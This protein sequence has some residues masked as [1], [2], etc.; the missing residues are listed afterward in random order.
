MQNST[1]GRPGNSMGQAHEFTIIG[2]LK[3][4]GAV[5]MR[6]VFEGGFIGKRREGVDKVHTVHDLRFVT[7][8]NDTRM[9]FAST[10]DGGWEAYIDDFS[11]IIP[12]EIDLVFGELEGYPG[13]ADPSIKDWIAKHQVSAL[14]FYS[15]YPDATVRDIKKALELKATIN[16]LLDS[17]ST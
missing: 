11:T 6:E 17:L 14:G 3:P 12:Q 4:G 15:A 16:S 5:R 13:L 2:N 10:F 9:V 7:F 1:E 8:D